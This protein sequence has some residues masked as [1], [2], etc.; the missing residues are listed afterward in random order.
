MRNLI[1]LLVCGLFVFASALGHA[2]TLESPAPGAHVSGL[3]YIAGWK[4]HHGDVTVR[5]DGGGPIRMATRMPR[6]DTQAGCQGATDN[7]F[8]TQFN[9]AF[10]ADGSH[11]IVAYDNGMEFARSTFTVATFGEGVCGRG[12]G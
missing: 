11:T 7:G 12:A 3:G 1:G 8:I 5:I 6:A 2:A 4:C 9:W 10:L